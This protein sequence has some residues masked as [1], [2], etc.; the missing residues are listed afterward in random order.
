MALISLKTLFQCM[1]GG[2]AEAVHLL[3]ILNCLLPEETRP[4]NVAICRS[5]PTPSLWKE[6][7]LEG[8]L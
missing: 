2:I 1:K 4:H 5:R 8:T 6:F 7:Y 3:Y